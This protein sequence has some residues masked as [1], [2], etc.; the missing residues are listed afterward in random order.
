MTGRAAE[1]LLTPKLAVVGL[2]AGVASGLLGVGGGVVIVPLLV[3]WAGY[4]QRDA[5]AWSLG[6]IVPIA[7][8]GLIAYGVAGRVQLPEAAA[9]TVG[10]LVG[11]AIGA[12][13]LSRLPERTLKLAFGLALIAISLSMA[14]DA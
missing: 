5:H 3:I 8:A 13:L 4:A 12:D 14:L 1:P 11:A 6:A 7:L 9:L 10:S 2:L